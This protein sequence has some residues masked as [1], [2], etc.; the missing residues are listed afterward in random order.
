LQ[1]RRIGIADSRNLAV[2]SPRRQIA[3]GD[4]TV[5][6]NLRRAGK[7]LKSALIEAVARAHWKA[8]QSA[9]A[10]D[11]LGENS[12]ETWRDFEDGVTGELIGDA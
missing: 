12:G 5:I 2:I 7:G 3:T 6:L 9:M 10:T 1:T 4:D 8:V 11:S